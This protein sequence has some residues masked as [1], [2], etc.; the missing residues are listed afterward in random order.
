[1]Q[2]YALYRSPLKDR[3]L[4][5][6]VKVESKAI[7]V[8]LTDSTISRNTEECVGSP[9]NV[10]REQVERL[11]LPQAQQIVYPL[12]TPG[13]NE[14][15]PWCAKAEL[16]VRNIVLAFPLLQEL[17]DLPPHV[18]VAVVGSKAPAPASG[19]HRHPMLLAG[20]RASGWAG[21]ACE[22]R[23]EWLRIECCSAYWIVLPARRPSPAACGGAKQ[24]WAGRDSIDKQQLKQ[25]W[26]GGLKR[27][28][29]AHDICRRLSRPGNF[30]EG[31]CWDYVITKHAARLEGAQQRH[32]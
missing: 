14:A 31:Q 32:S 8:S 30:P 12:H 7:L 22:I 29:S 25:A 3:D 5:R 17:P 15:R 9:L 23:H 24:A 19:L 2:R 16:H 28:R 6:A 21:Q 13:A 11:H 4:A 1:M 18:A 27:D 26:C 10:R 20:S